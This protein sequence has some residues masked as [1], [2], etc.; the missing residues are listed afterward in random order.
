M[1]QPIR[2]LVAVFAILLLV[3]FT[4]AGMR[5]VATVHSGDVVEIEGGFTV[6]L[7]GICAPALDERLGRTVFDFTRSKLEG[8]RVIMS[9]WTTDNMA[10]GIVHDST[11]RAFANFEYSE[12]GKW[13]SISDELV[14]RGYAKVDTAYLPPYMTHL[15]ELQ[16]TAQKEHLGI[17]EMGKDSRSGR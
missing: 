1:Q 4:Q 14:R 2:T 11:G 16:R 8:K 10:S 7:S 9:T 17:W 5:T 3:T 15:L 13:L 6:R 12:A